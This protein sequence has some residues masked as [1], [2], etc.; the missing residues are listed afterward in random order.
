[1]VGGR[2]EDDSLDH[3]G[4]LRAKASEQA[5]AIADSITRR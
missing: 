3:R 5:R 4:D 2:D 1:M